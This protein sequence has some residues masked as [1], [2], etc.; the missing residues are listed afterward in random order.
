M[1]II[2]TGLKVVVNYGD[3]QLVRCGQVKTLNKIEVRIKLN[4][5][6]LILSQRGPWQPIEVDWIGVRG[7][8]LKFWKI[9]ILDSGWCPNKKQTDDVDNIQA[10]YPR[11]EALPPT[12]LTERSTRPLSFYGK[13]S[14]LYKRL[15]L[16]SMKILE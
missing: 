3:S 2:P 11:L 10:E 13:N 4:N 15:P 8:E 6:E 5:G 14:I 9:R 16:K 7:I 1:L 12:T